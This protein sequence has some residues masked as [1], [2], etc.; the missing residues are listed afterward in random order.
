[1]VRR[2]VFDVLGEEHVRNC[3]TLSKECFANVVS[4][5]YRRIRF[6]DHLVMYATM[7]PL[8]SLSFACESVPEDV[9]APTHPI[10]QSRP[11]ALHGERSSSRFSNRWFSASGGTIPG[12]PSSHTQFVRGGRDTDSKAETEFFYMQSKSFDDNTI[13]SSALLLL[14]GLDKSAWESC[15]D[16]DIEV[17]VSRRNP[18][19]P[20]KRAELARSL[21]DPE[22]SLN[23]VTINTFTLDGIELD[24]VVNVFQ[25]R[26]GNGLGSITSLELYDGDYNIRSLYD[27]L[28]VLSTSDCH[29]ELDGADDQPVD[30]KLNQLFK[31]IVWVRYQSAGDFAITVAVPRMVGFTASLFEPLHCYA[32]QPVPLTAFCILFHNHVLNTSGPFDATEY[33][34]PTMSRLARAMLAVAGPLCKYR[35]GF[36]RGTGDCSNIVQAG[37]ILS[38][39]LGRE[40]QAILCEE[41]KEKGWRRLEIHERIAVGS[42]GGL[43]SREQQVEE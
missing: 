10:P 5:L 16:I 29:V 26:S 14:N 38:E 32:G 11:D 1:V 31:D 6:R 40:I 25:A 12:H 15:F 33:A 2:W 28:A 34:L 39:M 9:P 36:S 41:L 35:V 3:L 43:R 4:V 8:V 21:A 18:S 27:L 13:G 20:R 30:L 17:S 24:T 37:D 19:Y 42:D 7:P 22:A 23:N